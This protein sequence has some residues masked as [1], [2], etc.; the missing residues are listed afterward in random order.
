MRQFQIVLF[1]SF[2]FLAIFFPRSLYA[3]PNATGLE[4]TNVG[5][6]CTGNNTARASWNVDSKSV[7]YS[8]R[9]YKHGGPWSG[10][11]NVQT[12]GPG[13]ACLDKNVNFNTKPA[14]HPTSHT[15]TIDPNGTY[16]F[17]VHS[18]GLDGSWSDGVRVNGLKCGP[19]PTPG[20]PQIWYT[21]ERLGGGVQL[22]SDARVD[23]YVPNGTCSSGNYNAINI[24]NSLGRQIGNIGSVSKYPNYTLSDTSQNRQS[25]WQGSW[26][27]GANA[28][29][30]AFYRMWGTKGYLCKTQTL[31]EPV[32]VSV[33]GAGTS[34]SINLC[35]SLS[36]ATTGSITVDQDVVLSF[37]LPTAPQAGSCS[38]AATI[39]GVN[40]NYGLLSVP[41]VFPFPS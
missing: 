19:T 34:N 3:A 22:A 32:S 4:V 15:F 39:N 1:S 17:W 40:T 7:G 27:T 33:P 10:C 18:R 20:V 13:E 29:S 38:R 2:A 23:I 30:G 25:C 35:E 28:M 11:V 14:Q 36:V 12:D 5:F 26:G 37:A 16:D 21:E 24:V 41:P 8:L 6:V 9:L 31:L